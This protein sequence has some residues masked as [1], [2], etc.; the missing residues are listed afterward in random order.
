M[1]FNFSGGRLGCSGA[2]KAQNLV[3]TAALPLITFD[4]GTIGSNIVLSNNDL[5]AA[6]GTST[7]ENTRSTVGRTTG[8]WVFEITSNFT[9][10]ASV[11]AAVGIMQGAT[12][13]T[14]E[15]G[16]DSTS[17]GLLADASG[18]ANP[19]EQ[20]QSVTW[21]VS[22]DTVMVL[23]DLDNGRLGFKNTTDESINFYVIETG[24]EYFA[25]VS[26]RGI[27]SN[28]TVNYGSD[29][30]DNSIPLGYQSWDGQQRAGPV[31]V[32]APVIFD[33]RTIGIGVG[34]EVSLD[35][36]GLVAT[37]LGSSDW[38]GLWGSE[39]KT[40]SGKFAFEIT[41]TFAL[42][43]GRDLSAGIAL[44]TA[45]VSNAYLGQTAGSIGVFQDGTGV[46]PSNNT[47]ALGTAW[48]SAN[49]T[50][51]VLLNLDDET[52]S[53]DVGSGPVEFTNATVSNLNS[54]F[55]AITLDDSAEATANF[56]ATPFV[57]TMP[58]GYTSWDGNQTT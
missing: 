52:L 6:G 46:Y 48:S 9:P 37:Q 15:L 32:T 23:A 26:L 8:K 28:V 47:Q 11:E 7:W 20:T 22:G 55:P 40:G 50:I 39:S 24:V 16:Q 45:D 34:A 14:T 38:Y 43:S 19:I 4:S 33:R 3:S 49:D 54:W 51:M 18:T 35:V 25:G 30:F 57:N 56:G 53:F 44:D 5:T 2:L 42:G 58:D 36:T 17:Y 13:V 41:T 29:L 1:S 27:S 31:D 10:S 21:N 12:T